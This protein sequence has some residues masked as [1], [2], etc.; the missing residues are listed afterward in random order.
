MSRGIGATQ[1][2][3]MEFFQRDPERMCTAIEL[4]C[5]ITGK[6][7]CDYSATVNV[8][9]ALRSLAARGVLACPQ[10]RGWANGRKRWALPA[11]AE[12]YREKSRRAGF[13]VDY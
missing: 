4:A 10:K 8:R 3:I 2:A 13:R 9:R 7:P 11:T 1:R 12:A 6:N 5:E